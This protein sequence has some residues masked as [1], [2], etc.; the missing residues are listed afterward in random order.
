MDKMIQKEREKEKCIQTFLEREARRKNRVVKEK[1]AE[2]ELREIKGEV[3]RQVKNIKHVFRSKMSKLKQE[4]ER[5]K[6]EKMKQLT[7]MKLR[8]TSMLIDQESKGSVSNCKQDKEEN[9][10]A[11]C[12]ARFPSTWFEN[13]FCR[14]KENFCGVCC[15]KEFSVRFADDREKC[16]YE[17][18][19][20]NGMISSSSSTKVSGTNE[21]A[22]VEIINNP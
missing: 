5:I 4:T 16:L 18:R 3:E 21:T 20:A 15:E 14:V 22:T 19:L 11:Y 9:K 10:V 1:Q 12:N 8:I 17:C 2:Q 7:N 6:M 13:K